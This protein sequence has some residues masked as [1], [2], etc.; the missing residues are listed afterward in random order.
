VDPMIELVAAE[1]EDLNAL[2]RSTDHLRHTLNQPGISQRISQVETPFL[3]P[4]TPG[5]ILRSQSF[6]DQPELTQWT[7]S[8]GVEVY[9]LRSEHAGDDV[10]VHY[11]SIGGAVALP[12][13]L[14]PAGQLA[15]NVASRSGLGQ[16]SNV[17]LN[18]YLKEKNIYF[19]PYI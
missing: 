4:A 15:V 6:D 16:L 10:Y 1:S 5:D 14:Y 11:S 8:N 12:R 17:Q 18:N 13:A 3:P 9:Y 19:A 7:L 2:Q